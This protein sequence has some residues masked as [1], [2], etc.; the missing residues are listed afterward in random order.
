MERRTPAVQ[1]VMDNE[2][3]YRPP[4][5][6]TFALDFLLIPLT[7]WLV[8]R[9][10]HPLTPEN[11]L[12]YVAAVSLP[13]APAMIL[14]MSRPGYNSF[15]VSGQPLKWKM[16]PERLTINLDRA[17]IYIFGEPGELEAICALLDDQCLVECR[18]AAT[19]TGGIFHVKPANI[20]V[21]P[22]HPDASGERMS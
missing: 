8:V 20:Q 10:G 15:R 9:L 21:T 18:E 6:V 7:V 22:L 1:T 16:Q 12:Y 2:Q 5:K 3:E 13:I 17:D 11:E 14:R 19:Y 4:E